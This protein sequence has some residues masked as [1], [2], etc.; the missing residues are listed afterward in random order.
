MAKEL[1]LRGGTTANHS[2]FTGKVR[3]VTVD[4]DKNTVVVHDGITPGG[5]PLATQADILSLINDATPSEITVYSGVKT[6][7]LH[8]AQATAIANLSGASGSLVNTTTP[9]FSPIP[10]V[11]TDMPFSIGQQSTDTTIFEIN[12]VANT[13][14]FKR[15]GNYNFLSTVG[16]Q[17]TSG[18]TRTATFELVNTADSAILAS[19]AIAIDIP[20]GGIESIP[21][22]TLVTVGSGGIPAAPLTIKIMAKID[23]GT[24]MNLLNFSSILALAASAN[25]STVESIDTALGTIY[26]GLA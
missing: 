24:T 5:H 3:E 23:L 7:S 19:Q 2:A 13:I 10:L 22:N 1:Q 21:L 20:S 16:F 4:T 26:E 9:V 18:N 6:Q 12:D 25:A 17:S 14:T 15:D 11:S 8:D